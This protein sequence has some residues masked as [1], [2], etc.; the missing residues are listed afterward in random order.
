[1]WP[2]H[3]A[4]N[5][6]GYPGMMPP[7]SVSAADP[8]SLYANLMGLP[9]GSVFPPPHGL[10]P[11][12]LPGASAASRLDPFADPYRSLAMYGAPGK[13][14]L[15]EA[16]ELELMRMAGANPL[17]SMLEQDRARLAAMGLPPHS[18]AYLPPTSALGALGAGAAAQAAAYQS[19]GIP[20]M[21]PGGAKPSPFGM[22]PPPA[23]LGG[24]GALPGSLGVPPRL[25]PPLTPT[26]NGASIP[27]TPAPPPHGA[28]PR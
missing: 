25:T 22:F 17:G 27:G 6:F 4:P 20:G 15:R 2:G 11:G 7:T 8:R 28:I 12:A 16:R 1:M 14:P 9:P 21:P 3:G 23:G 19:L 5:P 13:D 10:P 18:S 26:M 24:L